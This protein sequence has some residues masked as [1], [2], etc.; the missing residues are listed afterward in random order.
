MAFLGWFGPRGLAS[1]VLLLIAM[2]EAPGIPGLPT[3]GLVVATTI[4]LSVYAHGISANPAIARYARV[5][6]RLPAD[7]PEKREVV[8]EVPTRQ[9]VPGTAKS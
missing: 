4:L 1:I 9:G 3:I 6:A 8:L 7:A 2:D 5:V